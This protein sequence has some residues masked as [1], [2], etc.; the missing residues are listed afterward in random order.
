MSRPDTNIKPYIQMTMER[1]VTSLTPSAV[2][3]ILS[4]NRNC[5]QNMLVSR[6]YLVSSKSVSLM[7]VNGWMVLVNKDLLFLLLVS[8]TRCQDQPSLGIS[9]QT[10]DR[11]VQSKIRNQ[12]V[13]STFHLTFILNLNDTTFILLLL[14]LLLC[15]FGNCCFGLLVFHCSAKFCEDLWNIKCHS[16]K[17]SDNW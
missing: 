1:E 8:R 2:K 16:I 11:Y 12:S 17:F 4:R 13:D 14:F 15:I 9:H 3:T 5:P 10:N 7:T 6:L